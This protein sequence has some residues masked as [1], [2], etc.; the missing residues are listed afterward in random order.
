MK[1]TIIRVEIRETE[2]GRFYASSPD[3][4][5]LNIS[6]ST[7]EKL[8]NEIPQVIRMLFAA[9]GKNVSVIEADA[10]DEKGKAPWIAVP[11]NAVSELHA[12]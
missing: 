9:Q 3:L 2:E 4:W 10:L 6:S 8:N 11:L 12:N 7:I 1:A 5:G